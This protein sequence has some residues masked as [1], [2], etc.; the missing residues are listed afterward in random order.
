[1]SVID[2][3]S[4]DVL[5]KLRSAKEDIFSKVSSNQG[6][7]A[8]HVGMPNQNIQRDL[9]GSGGLFGGR[10]SRMSRK[11][12]KGHKGRKHQKSHKK[13]KRVH[14]SKSHRRRRH[15]KNKKGGYHVQFTMKSPTH[16]LGP[17]AGHA[18]FTRVSKDG[19]NA[20]HK[21]GAGHQWSGVGGGSYGIA[22]P[23]GVPY[24]TTAMNDTHSLRGSY[25]EIIGKTHGCP[26][27]SQGGAKKHRRRSHKSRKSQSMKRTHRGGRRHRRVSRKGQRKS[28]RRSRSKKGGYHQYLNGS[29]RSF[30]YRTAGNIHPKDSALAGHGLMSAYKMGD[31]G[32]KGNYNHFT[33]KN[34]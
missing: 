32:M 14:K 15:S 16:L 3:H 9:V 23:T 1:M 5:S 31:Y 12:R 8:G 13:G 29:A 11:S 28:A 26:T 4:K 22:S 33:G 18:D 10:K 7:V 30:G 24:Y 17:K 2:L 19:Y 34:T 21:L 25:P 6:A 20:P 27:C